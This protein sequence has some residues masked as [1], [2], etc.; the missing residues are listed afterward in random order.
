M[1]HHPTEASNLLASF[2]SLTQQQQAVFFLIAEGLSNAQIA[3]RLG[4]TLY[5][6]KVQRAAALSRM[7]CSSLAAITGQ[8]EF[9]KSHCRAKGD[10]DSAGE[11]SF[12]R[13]STLRWDDL[14]QILEIREL[15]QLAAH[16]GRLV[17]AMGF[18]TF[19]F[20]SAPL[21]AD[22]EIDDQRLASLGN[23]P[24][25]WVLRYYEQ[26]F[27]QIDPVAWH[28]MRHHYPLA[29]TTD[30]FLA[31]PESADFYEEAR[32]F[33]ISS[34]GT[35]P[36][37][38]GTEGFTGLSFARDGD[39]DAALRDVRRVLPNMYV[40]T[41]YVYETLKKF[42]PTPSSFGPCPP[43]EAPRL[44]DQEREC[45]LRAAAGL[46][47]GDIADQLNLTRRTVHF[48]F[49]NVRRKL[50]AASRT[51]MIAKAILQGLVSI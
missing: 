17:N 30:M 23:Y 15:P 3:D 1:A 27:K 48:H 36:Q 49:A 14:F 13:C 46:S 9:V 44:T 11:V 43:T 47:D 5:R 29:W 42:L 8:V 2:D 34:G 12:S 32:A 33:G 41:S 7:G 25:S 20:Y 51:Q 19:Y 50:G 4:I 45:V 21:S 39:A 28:C 40:L 24:D 38:T 26:D 16:T 35:C 31:T 37:I 10:V 22:A 6:V 18:D